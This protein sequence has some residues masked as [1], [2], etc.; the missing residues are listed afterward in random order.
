[1]GNMKVIRRDS[2]P[3]WTA[4][5]TF[6]KQWDLTLILEHGET[7]RITAR[8]ENIETK[9]GQLLTSVYGQDLYSEKVAVQDYVDKISGKLLVYKAMDNKQR[10]EINCPP[11]FNDFIE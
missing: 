4:L 6:A 11:L 9:N 1:M 8:F 3:L 10:K 2:R 5:T 7:G